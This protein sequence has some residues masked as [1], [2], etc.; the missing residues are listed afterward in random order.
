MDN[1]NQVFTEAT[2]AGSSRAR[3]NEGHNQ[4]SAPSTVVANRYNASS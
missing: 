2:Y 4:V 1:E 3:I